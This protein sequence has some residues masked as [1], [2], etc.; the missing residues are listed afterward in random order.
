MF[1]SSRVLHLSLWFPYTLPE[2]LPIV[3]LSNTCH[4][5]TFVLVDFMEK[6]HMDKAGRNFQFSSVVQS[7]LTLCDPVDC[8]MP[9]FPV[10]HQLSELTQTHVHWVGEAIQPSHPLMSPLPPTFN[11]SQ[12]QGLFQW[13]SSL[14]QV[15]KVLGLQL[16][17]QSFQWIFRVDFL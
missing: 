15:A 12:H 7:C 10:H 8:S 2:C 4:M 17:H 1:S 11:C 9:G 14:P 6:L 3:P 13:V 16:Q 5:T